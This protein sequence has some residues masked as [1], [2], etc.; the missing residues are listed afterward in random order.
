MENIKII[1]KLLTTLFLKI[2]RR[3]NEK[4]AVYIL[5]KVI[6]D[7]KNNYPYLSFIIIDNA[8]YKE[9]ID[10]IKIN[11]DKLFNRLSSQSLNKC[12]KEIFELTIKY[13]QRD[14]DY[15]FIREFKEA[16]NKIDGLLLN[17]KELDLNRLQ[18]KYLIERKQELKI[19]NSNIFKT[20][21]LSLIQT[22]NKLSNNLK[23]YVLFDAILKSSY[24]KF[25]FLKTIKLKKEN[26]TVNS[27][28]LYIDPSIDFIP[29]Y[30]ISKSIIYLIEEIGKKIDNEHKNIYIETL[31]NEIDNETNLILKKIGV[32]LNLLNFSLLKV[33]FED[34]LDK[35]LLA[36]FSIL[37]EEKSKD[38]VILNMREISRDSLTSMK[39]NKFGLSS[40]L[41]A[42]LP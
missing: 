1:S 36:L 16:V 3:T 5:K 35:I 17:D 12:I 20:I 37:L 40:Q 26:D 23:P 25:D 34:I 15:F 7:L 19:K 42:F 4:N 18:Y 24:H 10:Y 6:N 9:N 41:L 31:K 8:H 21:I 13:L 11:N 27:Y 28:Y 30:Q 2:S 32:N 29:T 33:N 14:A 39:F 38:I 22:I